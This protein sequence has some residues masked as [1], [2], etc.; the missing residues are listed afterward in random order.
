MFIRWILL[1]LCRSRA[2]LRLV[3]RAVQR[4]AED[5]ADDRSKKFGKDRRINRSFRLSM[6]VAALIVY[7]ERPQLFA[8]ALLSVPVVMILLCVRLVVFVLNNW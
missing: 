4:Q 2:E 7:R 6:A 8:L 5:S 3:L 1:N